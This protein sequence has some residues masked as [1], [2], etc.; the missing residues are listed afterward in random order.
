[1]YSGIYIYIIYRVLF[2]I[3]LN[4][5]FQKDVLNF[6][7]YLPNLNY[8]VE[9]K[10]QTSQF[11]RTCQWCLHDYGTTSKPPRAL[12]LI[13]PHTLASFPVTSY[14]TWALVPIKTPRNLLVISQIYHI[15]SHPHAL[16]MPFSLLVMS[17]IYFLFLF[18][19][20]FFF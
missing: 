4:V 16:H 12:C 7:I 1:M 2:D 8:F 20:S 6:P 19:I 3:S 14:P 11:G 5:F 9:I 10:T 15:L 17:S 18:F 13:S